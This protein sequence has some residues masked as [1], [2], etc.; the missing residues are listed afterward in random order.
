MSYLYR[1]PEKPIT[2]Q[3][4]SPTLTKHADQS[5]VTA[6]RKDP[7]ANGVRRKECLCEALYIAFPLGLPP[8]AF[9][10][11]LVMTYIETKV[12]E[13]VIRRSLGSL[14]VSTDMS[15][16]EHEPQAPMSDLSNTSIR[17]EGNKV[18]ADTPEASAPSEPHHQQQQQQQEQ[19]DNATSSYPPTSGG[20]YVPRDAQSVM[21]D[22][23]K[24]P[25][26]GSGSLA[27][28]FEVQASSS[29]S[30]T[31]TNAQDP[32]PPSSPVQGANDSR[33][34]S[35]RSSVLQPQLAG[36]TA[37]DIYG[38]VLVD[39]DHALGPKVEWS[40]PSTLKEDHK[41][42]IDELPF[43][44]LPDGAHSVRL[45]PFLCLLCSSRPLD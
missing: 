7:L 12:A 43:L 44:A 6:R 8:C 15:N 16:D 26:T 2:D 25:L 42:L 29:S 45:S 41:S 32:S 24:D 19:E 14:G 36:L 13:A 20:T 21:L 37:P 39:F 23:R 11:R 18:E 22:T 33:A 40:S 1:G 27:P 17:S 30:G 10:V 3:P 31:L 9:Q 34:S 38:V 5:C 28:P 35:K 4:G